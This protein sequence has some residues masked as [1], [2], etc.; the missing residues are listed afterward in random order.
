MYKRK[1]K[2]ATKIQSIQRMRVVLLY[3]N[4]FYRERLW[5]YRAARYLALRAQKIFRG[6]LGRRQ[7][8]FLYEKKILPDPADARNF[9]VWVQIQEDANPPKRRWGIYAEYLR[10]DVKFFV[11]TITKRVSWQQ[12]IGWQV[13]DKSE[14]NRRQEVHLMGYSI[15]CYDAAQKMQSLWR[16][17][18]IS[19]FVNNNR[20]NFIILLLMKISS[21]IELCIG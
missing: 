19:D 14:F 18:V 2:S 5:W 3:F 7:Y 1:Q 10:K 12:P 11:N 20:Y 8:K 13:I 4:S 9:D 16:A 15:N 21:G 17:K 6:Y